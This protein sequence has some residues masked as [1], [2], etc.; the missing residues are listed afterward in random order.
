MLFDRPRPMKLSPKQRR[1]LK[2]GI[3]CLAALLVLE[4]DASAQK[5][6]GGK[7]RGGRAANAARHGGGGVVVGRK[8]SSNV[9]TGV[10][11]TNPDAPPVTNFG[12][13]SES[14]KAS[15]KRFQELLNKI[16]KAIAEADQRAKELEV[17]P[18]ASAIPLPRDLAPGSDAWND[19]QRPIFEACDRDGSGWMSYREAHDSLGLDRAEYL[20]Y[21]RDHDGRVGSREFIA[22]YDEVVQATGAFP[23]P[24]PVDDASTALPRSPRQLAAS[25]DTNGDGGLDT[26]E[27]G[28]LLRDYDREEIDAK[29]AV[30]RLDDDASGRID[31]PEIAQL[32]RLV[33]AAFL[34]P[35][36]RAAA[37][38]KTPRAVEELFCE[39]TERSG[40]RD[41]TPLPPLIGGPVTFFRRLDLDGDGY[42]GLV[43]L[44]ELQSPLTMSVRS[45]AVLA[46]LDADEDNRISRKEYLDSLRPA[47]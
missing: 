42:V 15:E 6:K 22:R 20:L 2:L 12:G 21:D 41:H 26:T 27:I 30:D 16:D 29:L 3:G 25:F 14:T 40:E 37:R 38:R 31:G 43:E 28:Q 18:P 35:D 23:I 33:S 32:S 39:V 10:L 13:A 4:L 24:R 47:R 17:E 1:L 11:K 34:L 46:A 36:A 9:P 8:R 19:L 7:R 5:K 44:Q 45:G